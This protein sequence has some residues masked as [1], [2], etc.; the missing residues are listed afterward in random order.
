M[1]VHIRDLGDPCVATNKDCL[2]NVGTLP[3]S[4]RSRTLSHYPHGPYRTARKGKSLRVRDGPWTE[5]NDKKRGKGQ[6]KDPPTRDDSGD[7][8]TDVSKGDLLSC[9]SDAAETEARDDGTG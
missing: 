8:G 5:E 7:G 9:V 1:E 4:T 3:R 2:P 6:G